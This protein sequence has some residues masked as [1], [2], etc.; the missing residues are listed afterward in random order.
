MSPGRRDPALR[1]PHRLK[2]LRQKD[3]AGAL[4]D[5][6]TIGDDVEQPL[7]RHQLVRIIT[8]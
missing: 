8:L 3:L 5:G 7:E 6:S 4:L 1:D 2:E